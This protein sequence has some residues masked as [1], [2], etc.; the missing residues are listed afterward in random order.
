MKRHSNWK[1]LNPVNEEEVEPIEHMINSFKNKKSPGND[2]IK[3]ENLKEFK[4]NHCIS[5]YIL[6]RILDTGCYPDC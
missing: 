4:K 3:S 5:T 6:N 2:E 1:I